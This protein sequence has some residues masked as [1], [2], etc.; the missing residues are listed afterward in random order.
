MEQTTLV[1]DILV[2]KW[3]VIKCY[4]LHWV[5]NL[6]ATNLTQ[7]CNAYR[8]KW[9]NC[10]MPSVI[11]PATSRTNTRNYTKIKLFRLDMFML[12]KVKSRLAGG[13][14]WCWQGQGS[15]W[16]ACIAKHI[17]HIEPIMY[18]NSATKTLFSGIL[19]NHFHT[20]SWVNLDSHTQPIDLLKNTDQE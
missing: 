19:T 4:L 12:L 6:G 9:R 17:V 13:D 8:A 10:C 5:W 20:R 2:S 16:K 15:S 3:C 1:R 7:M 14:W 11:S 18:C